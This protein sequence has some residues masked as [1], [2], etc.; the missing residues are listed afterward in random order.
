RLG[1]RA[2]RGATVPAA[3]PADGRAG[4]AP[5]PR[6]LVRQRLD[7]RARA[8]RARRARLERA[9]LARDEPPRPGGAVRAARRRHEQPEAAAAVRAGAILA[10]RAL[11]VA[12]GGRGAVVRRADRV[13]AAGG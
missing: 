12:P 2:R 11:G 7:P 10:V 1:R 6:R 3:P 9:R 13:R 5:L 4:G 8:A